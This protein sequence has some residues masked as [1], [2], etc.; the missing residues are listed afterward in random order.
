[1][2]QLLINVVTGLTKLHKEPSPGQPQSEELSGE[3]APQASASTED[4]MEGV[5]YDTITLKWP[6]S[7]TP[8]SESTE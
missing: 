8:A 7:L 1:M 5:A 3:S 2:K 4:L 6:A